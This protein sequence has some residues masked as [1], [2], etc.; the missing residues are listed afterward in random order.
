[1][2]TPTERR[3]LAAARRESMQLLLREGPLEWTGTVSQRLRIL[4]RY[5]SGATKERILACAADAAA[6][7]RRKRK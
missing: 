5:Y 4:A 3:I 2:T 1:M 7:K 6:R